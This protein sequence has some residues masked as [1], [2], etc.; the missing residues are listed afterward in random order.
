MTISASTL[1]NIIAILRNIDRD[2]IEAVA[3]PITDNGW[4]AFRDN[5]H[6][7]YLR[8][9]GHLQ[10]SIARIVSE[11]MR[12]TEEIS[13]GAGCVCP[14]CRAVFHTEVLPGTEIW[15]F[16]CGRHY[17]PSASSPDFHGEPPALQSALHGKGDVA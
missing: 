16:N 14:T 12:P 15:C 3:G 17:R 10:D 1:R 5:P 2:Q 4:I 8:M 11:R 6:E 9:G 7:G 13:R